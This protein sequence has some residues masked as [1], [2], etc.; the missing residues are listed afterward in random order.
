M[1]RRFPERP[2]L[3]T[4]YPHRPVTAAPGVYAPQDDSLLL[5]ET[6]RRFTPVD[7]RSV[8]DLCAGSGIAAVTA[9]QL[10]ARRVTAIDVSRRAVRCTRRNAR[11]AVVQVDARVGTLSDALAHGPYDVV[12][13][14][15]PYVPTEP[16]DATSSLPDHIGPSRA[17]DAGT[18]GRAVLDPLCDAAPGLLTR[19][20]VLLIV[21]S[22]FADP[23]RTLRM[24]RRGGIAAETIATQRIPFGPVL[25]ARA[26]W[27]ERV[28]LLD[29][30]RRDEELVV[31]RGRKQ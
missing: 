7:E 20:G 24:L 26:T 5:V 30:G 28:G 19:G 9:A 4:S 3:R 18:D 2:M 21:H 22:E 16:G 13:C 27:M 11:A 12:L 8:L 1:V 17:W 10:G 29:R 23:S 14:N 31:V 6:M 15:P 25:T